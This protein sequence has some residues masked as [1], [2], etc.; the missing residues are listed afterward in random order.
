[1]HASGVRNIEQKYLTDAGI[2]GNMQCFIAHLLIGEHLQVYGL[3]P[4]VELSYYGTLTMVF[5][6]STRTSEACRL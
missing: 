4:P 3:S 1:M 2:C 5:A 6:K